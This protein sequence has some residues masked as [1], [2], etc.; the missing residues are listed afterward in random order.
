MNQTAYVYQDLLI[1]K[2][3]RG[4]RHTQIDVVVLTTRAT[5]VIE[6]K[7][8]KGLI[9]G[10][11]K[12]KYWYQTGYKGKKRRRLYSPIMQNKTHMEA[13]L[14][15]NKKQKIIPIVLFYNENGETRLSVESVNTIVILEK[16]LTS[17]LEK[18]FKKEEYIDQTELDILD[19]LLSRVNKPV[20]SK[21]RQAHLKWVKAIKRN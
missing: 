15:L 14:T 2:K 17:I 5:L 20:G 6:V 13:L 19:G 4:E 18:V 11:E 1:P 12:N 16:H 8:M 9:Q 7:S 3:P 21:E 10:K